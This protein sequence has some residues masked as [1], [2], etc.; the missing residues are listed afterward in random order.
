M[1]ITARYASRC[2]ACGGHIAPGDCI[3]WERGNQPAHTQCPAPPV[4]EY[5]AA[6]SG[7]KGNYGPCR[8]CGTYCY[9]DCT[10]SQED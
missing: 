3:E 10:A 4:S 7:R 8:R 2:R 1:T 6:P 5:T 9:G